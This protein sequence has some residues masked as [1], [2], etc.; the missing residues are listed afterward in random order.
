V[1][2]GAAYDDSHDPHEEID[3]EVSDLRATNSDV[4]G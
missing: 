1:S 3:D 4:A 2:A